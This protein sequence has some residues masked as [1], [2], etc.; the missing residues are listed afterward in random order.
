MSVTA[1]SLVSYITDNLPA[2]DPVRLERGMVDGRRESTPVSRRAPVNLDVLGLLDRR[3]GGLATLM[4]WAHRVRYELRLPR[5]PG[6]TL[7][8]ES[9]VLTEYWRW[10]LAQPWGPRMVAELTALADT[11]HEVRYGVP[12]RPCPVCS[13]PVRVDRFTIEHRAC[14]T[15]QPPIDRQGR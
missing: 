4:F 11:V 13:E 1:S 6:H 7:S 14:L 3:T 8:T 2:L 9:A 12:V 15:D 5:V 10:A